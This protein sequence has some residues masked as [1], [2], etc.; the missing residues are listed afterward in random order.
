MLMQSATEPQRLSAVIGAKGG[1]V[2]CPSVTRNVRH[3]LG[4]TETR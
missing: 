3:V 4:V 2:R 1:K